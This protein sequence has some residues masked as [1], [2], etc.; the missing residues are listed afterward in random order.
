M[1][2]ATPQPRVRMHIAQHAAQQQME[3][4]LP[5]RPLQTSQS[6]LSQ[7][8]HMA[9]LGGDLVISVANFLRPD[10]VA[11]LGSTS[12]HLRAAIGSDPGHQ[13]M[14]VA[15]A[16]SHAN[17]SDANSDQLAAANAHRLG[18]QP[19][20]LVD[21]ESAVV[22]VR[23]L[24]MKL[25]EML[26]KDEV[27]FARV[28]NACSVLNQRC[29]IIESRGWD[30][31]ELLRQTFD[32][33]LRPWIRSDK[34]ERLAQRLAPLRGNDEAGEAK[35]IVALM[36]EVAEQHVHDPS[37]A[38]IKPFVDTVFACAAA[39]QD[40]S[41][42]P[43]G[44][45]SWGYRILVAA[46]TVND[47]FD[48][49][50]T[51]QNLTNARQYCYALLSKMH[52]SDTISHRNFMDGLRQNAQADSP[53]ARLID[54]I[55]SVGGEVVPMTT[56]ERSRL[57]ESLVQALRNREISMSILGKV[58]PEFDIAPVLEAALKTRSLGTHDVQAMDINWQLIRE[59][60]LQ[61]RIESHFRLV[62]N[63]DDQVQE[64]ILRLYNAVDDSEDDDGGDIEDENDVHVR[65]LMNAPFT[66]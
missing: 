16:N 51:P 14:L 57:G 59:E 46:K 58:H 1:T 9:R 22:A 49:L 55:Q 53:F 15:A 38:V 65:G 8:G 21:A 19:T 45:T 29:R 2:A 10:E 61:S 3:S 33:E 31:V 39:S 44:P 43:D 5:N 52:M 24:C 27:N 17:P 66:S 4:D 20:S 12:Q 60:L 50:P 48:G 26:D 35:F 40:T 56:A 42:P 11:S 6:Q 64:V 30:S 32:G 28:S 54:L 37:K 47:I 13:R 18:L 25:L 62:R 63:Q 23:L 34:C 7:A 41:L 36:C